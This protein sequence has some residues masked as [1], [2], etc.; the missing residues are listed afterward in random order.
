MWTLR[1][2]RKCGFEFPRGQKEK[3]NMIESYILIMK[4]KKKKI[5][6]EG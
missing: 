3:G 1:V 2:G 4:K 5:F 6:F